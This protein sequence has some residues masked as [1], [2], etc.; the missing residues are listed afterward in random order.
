MCKANVS[1][2]DIKSDNDTTIVNNSTDGLVVVY[3]DC[4]SSEYCCGLSVA[5][6]ILTLLSSLAC[7]EL[8]EDPGIRHDIYE[9]LSEY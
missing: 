7:E 5:A 8:S 4:K 2:S 1:Q 9:L 6:T 3:W